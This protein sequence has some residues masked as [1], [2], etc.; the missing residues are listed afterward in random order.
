MRLD[1]GD[2]VRLTLKSGPVL[3]DPQSMTTN[4]EGRT[5]PTNPWR[6]LLGLPASVLV[7]Q[8][9][10]VSWGKDSGEQC[11][12]CGEPGVRATDAMPWSATAPALFM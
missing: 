6:A 12:M 7:C 5:A 8:I 1:S 10:D 9:C 2:F 3:A 11:W 4:A